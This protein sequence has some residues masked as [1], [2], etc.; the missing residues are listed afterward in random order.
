[1]DFTKGMLQCIG[2]K[3]FQR[4]LEL[5]EQ[6]RTTDEGFAALAEA[7]TAVKDVTKNY[8]KRQQRWIK[9]RF[10]RPKDKQVYGRARFKLILNIYLTFITCFSG[11]FQRHPEFVYSSLILR[12]C[13]VPT[14]LG[15]WWVITTK[16]SFVVTYENSSHFIKRK[17]HSNSSVNLCRKVFYNDRKITNKESVNLTDKLTYI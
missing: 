11:H 17:T 3:Q 10:L 9:N 6:S 13:F 14:V 7:L 4:Y 15:K 1:M 2:V 8:A 5:P 16:L 12:R